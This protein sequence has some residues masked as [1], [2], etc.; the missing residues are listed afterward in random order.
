MEIG[1]FCKDGPGKNNTKCFEE[2]RSHFGLWC[3]MSSPLILGF[4]MSDADRMDRVWPIITNKEAIAIDHSW[5]GS[6]GMLHKTL[7]NNSIEVWAKPLPKDQVAIL[8]LNAGQ[9]NTT[10]T[11]SVS[12][13]VPGQPQGTTMRD[14]WNHK[15]VPITN[16]RVLLQLNMHDSFLAVFGSTSFG[17]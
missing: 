8:V 11:L 13:D 9:T 2:E 1:N 7:H 17:G 3:M 14:V 15:D 10:V 5:A 16:G 6:P 4:N 12:D